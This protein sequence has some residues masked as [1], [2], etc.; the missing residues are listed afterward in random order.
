ML[1][2]VR[3][4]GVSPEQQGPDQLILWVQQ[5]ILTKNFRQADQ[6]LCKLG[7]A[8]L[9]TGFPVKSFNLW[10]IWPKLIRSVTGPFG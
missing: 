7:F 10:L 8:H 9:V 2:S 5:S 4:K 3:I 1:T 6:T